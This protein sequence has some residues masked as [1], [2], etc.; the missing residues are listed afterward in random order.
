MN[1]SGHLDELEI[2]FW[3]RV[4]RR[5]WKLVALITVLAT[6]VTMTALLI[7]GTTYTARTEIFVSGT[8]LAPEVQ[9]MQSRHVLDEV[10]AALGYRPDVSVSADATTFVVAIK[11]EGET[12]QEAAEVVDT[13]AATYVKLR[14]QVAEEAWQ[15]T[16]T[17]LERA[18][19]RTQQELAQVPRDDPDDIA[20]RLDREL[21]AYQNALASAANGMLA[22]DRTRPV[23]LS[24]ATTA[25][26]GGTVT[27]A[28]YGLA[29]AVVG[30]VAG[31]GIPA[32]SVG[33]SRGIGDPRGALQALRAP[34]LG[35]VPSAV[36]LARG[37]TTGWRR[38]RQSKDHGFL[39]SPGSAAAE[40]IALVRARLRPP[41]REKLRG[42]VQV[43]SAADVDRVNA[44][45]VAVNLAFS[46]ARSGIGC[47]LVWA[48]YRYSP[49]IL[50]EFCEVPGERG[51][52]DALI[53]A[54]SGRTPGLAD[55]QTPD[56]QTTVVG[57]VEP[58][59][60]GSDLAAQMHATA[61]PN[62][63]ILP[64]G[65]PPKSVIDHL[66]GRNFSQVITELTDLV[67]VVIVYTPPLAR[68]PDCQLVGRAVDA[69]V[70]VVSA[71]TR[72]DTLE[73]AEEDMR[74]AGA[75]V[76]GVIFAGAAEL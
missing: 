50:A 40:V 65:R 45:A 7:R 39:V 33:L 63:S 48:D 2:S 22:A 28:L 69:S 70:V 29:S 21:A 9:F 58:P 41:D 36:E 49:E 66:S 16:V 64:P 75:S 4:L 74:A 52:S 34:L 72:Q 12:A 18:I 76:D 19:T 56:D 3:G 26:T 23:V 30:L 67:D 43:C 53:A 37:S 57:V 27:V 38:R 44:A 11:G 1:R 61:E 14:K 17:D 68:Y 54:S 62:L 6:S 31:L 60:G 32:I 5:K 24:Q 35:T 59:T 46:C 71:Q 15:A 42:A 20:Q 51:L 13:Y 10:T 73:A 25:A 55:D 8:E 47:V